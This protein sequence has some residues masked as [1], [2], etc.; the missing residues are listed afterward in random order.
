MAIASGLGSQLGMSVA[1]STYGT[2]VAPTR[3]LRATSYTIEAGGVT[4]VQGEGI[5]TGLHVPLG[6]HYVETAKGYSA[7]I[8]TGLESKGLGLLLNG[9][10]GGTTTPSNLAGTAY[11]A[12]FTLG[13]PSGKSYSVQIGAPLTTGS[14]IAQSLSGCKVVSADFAFPVKGAATVS[15]SLDAQKFVTTESL[16]SAS[17]S[18]TNLFHG[19]QLAVKLGTYGSESAVSGVKNVQVS[20]KRTLETD[21]YY[22]S[23]SGLKSE[24]ILSGYAEIDVTLDADFLDKTVFQD[25]SLATSGVS[26]VIELVGPVITSTYYETF[27]IT[28]PGIHFEPAV[29]GVSGPGVLS[30]SWKGSY[31]YDGTNAASIYSISTDSTL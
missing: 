17:Y 12:T 31:K 19:G 16:A 22:A 7:K 6:A 9:L 23:G 3:F 26:M 25:R 15:W 10:M 30:N 27:R 21:R 11:G 5:Q 29:Q 20:V 1:E 28:L 2:F 8:D 24:P 13:D 14:V 4:R 18:S